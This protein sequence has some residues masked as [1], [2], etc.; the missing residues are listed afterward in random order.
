MAWYQ[1]VSEKY[2]LL[3][4]SWKA[5]TNEM[6]VAFLKVNKIKYEEGL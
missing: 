6:F 5:D 3:N 4:L 2:T 1:F